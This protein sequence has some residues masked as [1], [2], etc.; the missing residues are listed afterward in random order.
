VLLR[1]LHTAVEGT[2]G[3]GR[4]AIL[5]RIN[6]VVDRLTKV[7]GTEPLKLAKRWD[8]PATDEK[9]EGRKAG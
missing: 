9:Q 3:E 4:A 7:G 6:L 5:E 2:A 8:T 1:D